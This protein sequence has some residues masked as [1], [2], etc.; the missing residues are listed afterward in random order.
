MG[1]SLPLATVQRDENHLPLSILE[2]AEPSVRTGRTT[3]GEGMWWDVGHVGPWKD[4]VSP[5]ALCSPRAPDSK[6]LVLLSLLP[7]LRRDW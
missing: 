6:L 7:A 3:P 5:G 2:T 1:P 4:G